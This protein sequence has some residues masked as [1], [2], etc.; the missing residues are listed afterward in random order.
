MDSRGFVVCVHVCVFPHMSHY[1][2]F[3]KRLINYRNTASLFLEYQPHK[4]EL[5]VNIHII[6][7]SCKMHFPH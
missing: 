2:L 7:I 3:N 5:Q 1:S 4:K 6:I